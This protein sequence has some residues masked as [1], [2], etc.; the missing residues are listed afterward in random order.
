MEEFVNK[1]ID[2]TCGFCLYNKDEF[3]H[4]RQFGQQDLQNFIIAETPNFRVKPDILPGN[5][6]GRHMLVHPKKH[7]YNHAG[8]TKYAYEVGQLVYLLEQKFGPLV[9]FEHGGLRPG[10]SVQSIYHAHFHAYGGLE[11]VDVIGWMNHM[12]SGGLGPDE[13]YPHEIVSAPDYA[14]I[15]NLSDR[16]NGIPYL[17][18]EQGPWG[19]IVEDTEGRMK[20][21]ITQRSMHHFFSKEPLNWKSISDSKDL[22]RESV[23]RIRNLIE[24]CE[25]GEYNTHSF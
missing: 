19:L 8:L 25:H 12:L 3:P 15:T 9:I 4:F 22:A 6:D 7:V 2:S 11:G 5:P 10:N 14:F 13:I 1:D 17:Y 16:F 21:Q 18:V 24:F 23:C 20:S